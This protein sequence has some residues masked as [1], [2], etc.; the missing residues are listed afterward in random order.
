ML[1]LAQTM[2]DSNDISDLH[3]MGGL[4]ELGTFD[5]VLNADGAARR[6]VWELQDEAEQV[7]LGFE[8][9][10]EKPQMAQLCEL[11]VNGEDRFDMVG[12]EAG[13][14]GRRLMVGTT[15][16]IMM[17]QHLKSLP[18]V[19]A[20]RLGPSNF[21]LRRDALDNGWIGVRGEYVINVLANQGEEF[22]QRVCKV[23]SEVLTGATLK[24]RPKDTDRVELFLNS[25]DNGRTFRPAN[26]GFGYSYVL[27][28]VVSELLAETGSLLIVENPEAHLHPGAQSRLAK[29]LIEIAKKRNVQLMIETHSDH[30]VNGLRI[31]MKQQMAGLTPEDAEVI[32]FA[33]DEVD[34][35]P[36]VEIIQCDQRGELNRYPDDFLDEWTKQL[37]NLM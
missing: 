3:L 10:A 6:F 29:F 24:A 17:L 35:N 37:V 12:M 13:K 19:S 23:L 1:L 21:S 8:A 11:R 34:T 2:V 22:Q 26:V 27:P 33:H 14:G 30:V 25:V 18:Y 16:D 5:E 36:T 32:F 28:V 7:R 20:G 15:S 4:T 31:A 9:V